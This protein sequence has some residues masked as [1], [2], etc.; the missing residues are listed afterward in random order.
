MAN[1]FLHWFDLAFHGTHG[2]ARWSDARLVRYA[3]D[4]VVLAGRVDG[5]IRD[6]IESVLEGR[7]DLEI[8][9]EKTSVVN[10]GEAGQC[11]NFL[12]YSFR[13]DDDLQGR[14]WK[15]LNR[16]PSKKSLT[17]ARQAIR[18]LTAK[19]LG[20]LP[21]GLLVKRLN[22]FLIGWSN[23][24]STGYPRQAFRSINQFVQQRLRRHLQRRSQRSLQPPKDMNWR[25]F[26]YNRLGV[27][28][29]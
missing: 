1:S 10:V 14:P 23:Y 5:R 6:W 2:P 11:L 9:R 29:L 24:F 17:K 26:T 7:L 22:R 13:Y 19:R 12:G 27:V 8:N 16:F 4:F 21:I 18:E 15:Y 3:D 28:Q 25:Q 20:G